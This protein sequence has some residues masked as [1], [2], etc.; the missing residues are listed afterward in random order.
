MS[1]LGFSPAVEGLI[2]AREMGKCAFPACGR[3]VAHLDRG[4]GFGWAIH[5]RR[6][7]SKG[8]TSLG[9]VNAAANGVLLCEAHHRHVH[10]NPAESYASGFLV[11]ANGVQRSDEVAIKHGALGLVFLTD[12][13]GWIPVEEGPTPESMWK[14]VA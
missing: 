12:G 5:H 13:G 2:I 1:T 9:W 14:D 7:K 10:G 11:R 4:T 8:G 3:H 6:P